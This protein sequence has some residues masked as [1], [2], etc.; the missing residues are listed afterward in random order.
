MRKSV[1]P[2]F[3]ACRGVQVSEV[4]A[5]AR[6]AM[7]AMLEAEEALEGTMA[8]AVAL[9]STMDVA[10][11]SGGG[12]GGDGRGGGAREGGPGES[13]PLGEVVGEENLAGEPGEPAEEENGRAGQWPFRRAGRQESVSPQRREAPRKSGLEA[14][15][16]GHAAFTT[17]MGATEA[18]QVRARCRSRWNSHESTMQ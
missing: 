1:V 13:G 17:K 7:V 12:D 15:L 4:T 18:D 9:E 16:S 2:T 11:E 8:A 10:A 14:V 5:A 3:I 6:E